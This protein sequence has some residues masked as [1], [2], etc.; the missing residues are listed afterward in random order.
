VKILNEKP[1]YLVAQRNR[2]K[3]LQQLGSCALRLLQ[4]HFEAEL[5]KPPPGKTDSQDDDCNIHN[6]GHAQRGVKRIGWSHCAT[7]SL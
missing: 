5:L 3:D 4:Q 7:P 1:G 2:Q 6:S